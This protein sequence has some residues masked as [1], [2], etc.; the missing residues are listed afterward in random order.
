MKRLFLIAN[1]SRFLIL[2]GE[3]IPNLA[4][5]ILALNLKRLSLDYQEYYGHPVLLAETFVDSSRFRGSCYLGAGWQ[6]VGETRGFARK[7]N[8]YEAHGIKKRILLKP[9]CFDAVQRLRDP[10]Q[11]PVHPEEKT[12]IIN[13]KKLPIEGRGGLIDVLKTMTDPRSKFGKQHSFLSILAI[14]VCA[15]LSGCKSFEAIADWAKG[16]SKKDLK[17]LR[18][19]RDWPPSE[20]VIRTT[21]QRLDAGE[22]DS[23]VGGWLALQSAFQAEVKKAIAVDGK[24]ARGSHDGEKKAVHL[25][26]AFLHEQ[27]VTI[28]QLQVSEKTNEIPAIKDLLMPLPIQGALVTADAMHTQTE[29][30]RFIVKDKGADYLFIVKGNQ[31]TLE[32]QLKSYLGS[33][34]IGAFPPSS[35]E[36][37]TIH[38]T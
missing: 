5:R 4:S 7:K 8:G 28:A 24:T 2:P 34:E 16:L 17:K 18:C 13:Y 21:I 23:K 10:F 20:F 1:N 22:F 19:R 3:S 35:A 38:R 27:K 33:S 12:M 31:P 36:N 29:T 37:S 25:L 6:Q 30:G 9:L 11:D 32:A 14:A 15:M 26:S